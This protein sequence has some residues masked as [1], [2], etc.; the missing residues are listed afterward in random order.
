MKRRSASPV[1][2][3]RSREACAD[4]LRKKAPVIE[5]RGAFGAEAADEIA[6][7]A[8]R[9]RRTDRLTNAVAVLSG[10]GLLIPG[11]PPFAAAAIVSAVIMKHAGRERAASGY[12]LFRVPRGD[13]AVFLLIRRSGRA[14]TDPVEGCEEF[15]FSRGSACPACR[16]RLEAPRGASAWCGRCRKTVVRAEY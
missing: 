2:L 8:R 7:A 13:E 15:L 3:A 1:E 5:L 6:D 16:R 11:A 9:V 14:G 4:A 12:D 10:F